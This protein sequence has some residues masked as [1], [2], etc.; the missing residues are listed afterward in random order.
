MSSRDSRVR[1]S[2]EGIVESILTDP[3][4]IAGSLEILLQTANMSSQR[5]VMDQL[6]A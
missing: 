4:V 3:D 6:I 2:V 1:E 5:H